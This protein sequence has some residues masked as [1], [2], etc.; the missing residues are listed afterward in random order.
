MPNPDVLNL[1]SAV[2]IA[3]IKMMGVLMGVLISAFSTIYIV[4]YKAQKEAQKETIRRFD[5]IESLLQPLALEIQ[6]VKSKNQEIVETHLPAV[7]IEVKS[8]RT[9]LEEN[10]ERRIR[11]LEINLPMAHA[12][13]KK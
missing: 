9:I 1:P 2:L 4:Y 5:K 7:R 6:Q 8:A 13:A 12:H 10:H 3:V 11:D